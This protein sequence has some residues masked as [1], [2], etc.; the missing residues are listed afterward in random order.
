V[1][2]LQIS[3]QEMRERV[4]QMLDTLDLMPYA[5][6]APAQLSGG[7]QQRVALARAIVTQPKVLLFDEPL[8]NLDAQLPVMKAIG[9]REFGAVLRGEIVKEEALRWAQQ[10]TRRYAK[11]QLSWFRNQMRDENWQIFLEKQEI[12]L[13]FN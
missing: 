1:R 2:L 12:S 4:D 6:R 8:S 11:R 9:V 5:D 7:Q 3:R 10:E 13:N